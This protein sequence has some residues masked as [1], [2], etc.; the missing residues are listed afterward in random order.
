MFQ[1]AKCAS[2]DNADWSVSLDRATW[3]TCPKRNT[4]LRGLWRNSREEGDERVGRIEYGRCCQAI[5]P[6]YINK[7]ATCSNANWK[8]TLN[9]WVIRKMTISD[10]KAQQ[11]IA[12]SKLQNHW[13]E[14]LKEARS[15]VYWRILLN[16]N[17]LVDENI[18]IIWSCTIF[19]FFCH[20]SYQLLMKVFFPISNNCS[21]SQR[22]KFLV[23]NFVLDKSDHFFSVLMSG[24]CVQL[25]TTWT[26]SDW[27]LDHL[28][29]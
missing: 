2:C 5:E 19:R 7:P 11:N 17:L 16:N 28:H 6:S 20:Q 13:N 24:R 15:S 14:E 12:G 22:Y 25:V 9:G 4:Y 29:T 23:V 21:I 1:P 18:G 8:H 3:S 27:A 26:A 10:S